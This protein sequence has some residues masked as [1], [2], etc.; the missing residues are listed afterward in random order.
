M[1]SVYKYK[2]IDATGKIRNDSIEADNLLDLEQRLSGMGM[3][4][5]NYREKKS[6][7]FEFKSKGINRRDLINFTFQMQQLTKSGVSILDGLADLKDSVPEGRMKEVLSGL[8]DE[9]QG[10]K[11]FSGAL[12]EFPEIFDRFLYLISQQ[13]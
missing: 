3:D 13:F 5:I 10:G 1:P 12:A 11:T 7:L 6:G 9:I 4:L 8:V 2:A